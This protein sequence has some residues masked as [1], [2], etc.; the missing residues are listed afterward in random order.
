GVHQRG[1]GLFIRPT[2]KD[3]TPGMVVDATALGL[4]EMHIVERCEPTQQLAV[5]TRERAGS[6]A[7]EYVVGIGYQSVT[8]K[9]RLGA[10]EHHGIVRDRGQLE[11]VGTHLIAMGGRAPPCGRA[12]T[13]AR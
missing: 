13:T 12:A 11:V 8:P 10:M 9:R 4:T 6:D 3:R 1:I 5:R 2:P 7:L